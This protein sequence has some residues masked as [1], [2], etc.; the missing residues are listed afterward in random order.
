MESITRTVSD[1]L[2][3]RNTNSAKTD[4]FPEKRFFAWGSAFLRLWGIPLPCPFGRIIGPMADK[5]PQAEEVYALCGK[6][7]ATFAFFERQMSYFITKYYGAS[8]PDLF[9]V[10][11]MEQEYFGFELK[12][13]ILYRVLKRDFSEV[14]AS[15]PKK[16][17]GE[18][19]DLRN[20]TAHGSIGAIKSADSQELKAHLRHRGENHSILKVQED[21]ERI[22]IIVR[23]GFK[24]LPLISNEEL[25]VVVDKL[26]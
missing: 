15:F 14:F 17:F 16:E 19:R 25:D 18:L 21:F 26:S 12:L 2:K 4:H 23:T 1:E 5:F 9:M 24:S 10:D 8:K 7:Q 22:S 11:V 13:R 20:L 6:I 3:L